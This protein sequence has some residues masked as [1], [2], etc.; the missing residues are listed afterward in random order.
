MRPI[1]QRSRTFADLRRF[2]SLDNESGN[3]VDGEFSGV[4]S[5]SSLVEPGDLFIALP[6]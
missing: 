6:G 5:N 4:T 1:N 2:L 3:K